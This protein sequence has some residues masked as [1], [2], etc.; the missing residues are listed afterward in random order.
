MELAKWI[1]RKERFIKCHTEFQSKLG[2]MSEMDKTGQSAIQLLTTTL[3]Y[4][5]TMRSGA[6][7]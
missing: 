7:I 5:K 2:N 4:I 6:E 3:G 1:N